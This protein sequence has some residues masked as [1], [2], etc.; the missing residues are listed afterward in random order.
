M[1]VFGDGYIILAFKIEPHQSLEESFKKHSYPGYLNLINKCNDL[2]DLEHLKKDAELGSTR[3]DIIAKRIDKCKDGENE[4]N[5]SYY[6]YIKKHYIDNGITLD[7]VYKYRNWYK[8]VAYVRI[9]E[10]IKEI[11]ANRK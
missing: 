5:S 9:K 4:E 3:F 6:K 10:K 1:G 2:E 11:K 7:D 8:D